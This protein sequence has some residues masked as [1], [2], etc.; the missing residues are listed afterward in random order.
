[1]RLALAHG[2]IKR[3]VMKLERLSDPPQ[4]ARRG[5]I[6]RANAVLFLLLLC[7]VMAVAGA[8]Y[9]DSLLDRIRFAFVW[10][11]VTGMVGGVLLRLVFAGIDRSK[12]H[13]SRN[14]GTQ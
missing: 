13:A 3:T 14:K 12:K 4:Y 1:M 9:G 2:L 7:A 5:Q 6:G 10:S 8:L 11:G